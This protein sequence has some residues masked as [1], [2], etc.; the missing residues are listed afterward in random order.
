MS[1]TTDAQFV[2]V[3]P[4]PFDCHD[5]YRVTD[6]FIDQEIVTHATG[7]YVYT[8]GARPERERYRKQLIRIGA[9]RGFKVKSEKQA[10]GVH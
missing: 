5:V 10:H 2:F 1:V 4:M 7:E 8:D 9:G 3:R 6:R